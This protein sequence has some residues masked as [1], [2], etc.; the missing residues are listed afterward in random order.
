M[1]QHLMHFIPFIEPLNFHRAIHSPFRTA[2]INSLP[3]EVVEKI[4]DYLSS[5]DIANLRLVSR[6][7]RQFPH[8]EFRTFVAQEFPWLWERR[9]PEGKNG[10]H[11]ER[12]WFDFYRQI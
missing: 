12:D 8:H 6:R 4:L 9:E 11:N 2:T 7:F 5:K 10:I 1:T 3:N